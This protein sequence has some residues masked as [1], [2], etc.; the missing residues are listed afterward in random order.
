MPTNLS[1]KT[2]KPQPVP[3]P[4][5][6]YTQLRNQ[7]VTLVPSEAGIEQSQEMPNVWGVLMEMG[8]PQAVVTLVSLADGTTSMYFGNGGGMIGGGKHAA[9]A[10]A[11]KSLVSRSEEYFKNMT[12]TT[13][14]PLPAVGRVKFYVLTFSGTFT[15]DVDESELVKRK[16]DLSPLFYSGQEVITQLRL[17]QEQGK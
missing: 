16:H 1:R 2:Q 9:V 14:F 3:E 4:T 17:I 6:I 15:A 8:Y 12:L 11:S 7:I 10:T 5:Q 13:S